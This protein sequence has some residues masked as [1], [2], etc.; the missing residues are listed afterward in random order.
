MAFFT[1]LLCAGS[2]LP[3]GA[4]GQEFGGLPPWGLETPVSFSGAA[5]PD[6]TF[7]HPIGGGLAVQLVPTENGWEIDVGR[8]GDREDYAACS[9][10]PF[11]GPAPKQITASDFIGAQ[12]SPRWGVGQK[13]WID[14]VLTTEQL[15][16]Q[17]LSLERALNDGDTG[18][19]PQAT[20][21]CWLRPLS[22][23]SSHNAIDTL[24]FDGECALHGAWQLWRLPATYVIPDGF[25]G[26]VTVHYGRTGKPELPRDGNRYV[27]RIGEP[28]TVDTSS[29][30]REDN[31]GAQFVRSDGS[32]I[33]TEGPRRMIWDWRA[34]DGATCAP[35]QS[36][37]VGSTV[38][39]GGAGRNPALQNSPPDCS[40]G[41]Q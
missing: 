11:H 33:S 15:K 9:T 27:L 4:A 34:G 26:W 13:R 21:R 40:T 6:V 35:F 25:T 18:W 7:E 22:V 16:A 5:R 20:G 29:G 36:F 41:W 12:G 14:F 19:R 3:R 31:R 37:F 10:P 23:N 39:H 1:A 24:T 28:G 2:L 32:A 30:L 38:Q 17:C 8:P